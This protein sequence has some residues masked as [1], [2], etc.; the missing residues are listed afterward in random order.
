MTPTECPKSRMRG[1]FPSGNLYPPSN[2]TRFK[3]KGV[4][5]ACGGWA[6]YL[7]VQAVTA[8][9]QNPKG[10]LHAVVAPVPGA[11]LHVRC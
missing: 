5:I 2:T 4:G 11:L 6:G 1:K 3:V 7:N 10:C 8:N 9:K